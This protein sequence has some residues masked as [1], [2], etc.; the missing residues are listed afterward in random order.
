MTR[1]KANITILSYFNNFVLKVENVLFKVSLVLLTFPWLK[2]VLH[3]LIALVAALLHVCLFAVEAG[4]L[5]LR[6][7]F[8]FLLLCPADF[9]I[10]V[11]VYVFINL[12]KNKFPL[13]SGSFSNATTAMP[14]LNLQFYIINIS[15]Y[16]I[17]FVKA[18]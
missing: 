15:L 10:A 16:V 6:G 14:L 4:V 1:V 13:T 2:G 7:F 12:P 11:L 18:S 5:C 8:L 17:S 3:I 9:I